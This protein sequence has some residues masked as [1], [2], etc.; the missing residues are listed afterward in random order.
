MTFHQPQ[1]KF[2]FCAR[3]QMP[4]LEMTPAKHRCV[5]A[6]RSQ[7]VKHVAFT[8]KSRSS[9]TRLHCFLPKNAVDISFFVVNVP[10][11]RRLGPGGPP[12]SGTDLDNWALLCA[13]AGQQSGTEWSRPP[14]QPTDD[15]PSVTAQITPSPARRASVHQQSHSR[16]DLLSASY[17][18]KNPTLKSWISPTQKVFP[19]EHAA[20]GRRERHQL[21]QPRI[22]IRSICRTATM[23]VGHLAEHWLLGLYE[24]ANIFRFVLPR[25]S[26]PFFL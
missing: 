8:L 25:N 24:S 4:H 26:F 16:L 13:P 12:L 5:S 3:Q 10:R 19:L 2:V 6:G 1:L 7:R 15:S 22:F 20:A 18:F 11:F 23:D 17:V 21:L 9:W 14:W